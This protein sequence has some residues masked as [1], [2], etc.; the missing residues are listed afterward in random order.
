MPNERCA[1]DYL[2]LSF[3]G[4]TEIYTRTIKTLSGRQNCFEL[5]AKNDGQHHTSG[6]NKRAFNPILYR[7]RW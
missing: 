2:H 6:G 3:T 7:N 1:I 5:P 4:H